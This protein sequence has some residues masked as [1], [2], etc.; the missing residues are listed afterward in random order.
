MDKPLGRKT[1]GSI[2]HIPGSRADNA[3]DHYITQGQANIAILQ[4]RDNN[5]VVICQEKLDGSCVGIALKDGVLIP[6]GRSGYPAISSPYLQ[7]VYFHNWVHRNEDRFRPVLKEGERVV[8]EWLSQAH[9]TR[10]DLDGRS[11]FVPFDIL[12][13]TKRIPFGRFVVRLKY[14]RFE[15]PPTISLGKPCSVETA[16]ERLG[17]HGLYG[18][19]DGPEG[20]VWRV[21]RNGKVDFLCK[22]VRA[23][24]QAG[25]YLMQ[26]PH[27]WNWKP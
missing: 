4:M 8:G 7:H 12:K 1:Y 18:A 23:D 5:D 20:C 19:I 6:L 11:P 17:E 22:F 14:G 3:G 25:K 10:Y 21:E 27:I 13:G 9:G 15:P 24:Y 16:M 26:D 2:P